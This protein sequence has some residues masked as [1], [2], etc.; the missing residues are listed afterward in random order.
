MITERNT[1]RFNRWFTEQPNGCWLWGQAPSDNGYGYFG[2]KTSE[3]KYKKIRAHRYAWLLHRG[4]IPE[5]MEVCHSCDSKL[6]VNPDHLYLADHAQNMHDA[7]M[8]GRFG[9]P[10]V[11]CLQQQYA[12][13][14]QPDK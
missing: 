10:M 5:G 1:E 11:Y 3:G 14:I 12:A 8:R 9:G 6:C 2:V 7:S 13:A 4:E